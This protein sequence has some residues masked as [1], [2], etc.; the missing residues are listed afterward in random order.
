MKIYLHLSNEG[1]EGLN[2]KAIQT[3]KQVGVLVVTNIE[4][5]Y[6]A[7][8]SEKELKKL[9]MSGQNLLDKMDA[10]V[11]EATSP[12][13]EVG[14]LLAYAM[15]QKK[16][17]LY[18]ILKGTKLGPRLKRLP[19]NVKIK[20]YTE[21]EISE[22]LLDFLKLLEKG[23]EDASAN[24]KFTLRI[25]PQ[26]ERYLQWK[27]KRKKLSKADFLREKIVSDLIE[28]DEEYKKYL[29]RT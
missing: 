7:D 28:N 29:K 6:E 25:T 4:E 21:D 22:E 8:F 11:I 24:I 2:E 19:D 5:N 3:L 26:I 10:F 1:K 17:V 20:E 9:K 16:P 27:S 12:D 14:Y 13:P 15:S 23:W 18:L